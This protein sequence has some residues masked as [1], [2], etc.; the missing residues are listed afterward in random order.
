MTKRTKVAKVVRGAAAISATMQMA[1]I[2][3]FI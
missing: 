3:P 2:K 1:A